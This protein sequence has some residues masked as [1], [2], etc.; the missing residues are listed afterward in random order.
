MNF[1]ESQDKIENRFQFRS[2]EYYE[3]ADEVERRSGCMTQLQKCL[4]PLLQQGKV[5]ACVLQLD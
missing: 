4:E 1:N 3:T 2:S 5:E